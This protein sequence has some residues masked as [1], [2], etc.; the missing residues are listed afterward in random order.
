M[1]FFICFGMIIIF[2]F[3]LRKIC[4]RL[5]LIKY[6]NDKYMKNI[7]GKNNSFYTLNNYLMYYIKLVKVIQ[8]VIKVLPYLKAN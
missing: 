5:R 4:N 1:I 3:F 7:L 6:E 8:K 2:T